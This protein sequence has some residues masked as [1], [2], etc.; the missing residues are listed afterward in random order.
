MERNLSGTVDELEDVLVEFCFLSVRGVM[1][2]SNPPLIT[3]HETVF[4][5]CSESILI[6]M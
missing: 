3:T 1:Y 5:I 6:S 4:S 2:L